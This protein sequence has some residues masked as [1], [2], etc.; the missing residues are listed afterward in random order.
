VAD[1][2]L[3]FQFHGSSAS[4]AEALVRPETMRSSTSVR[5]AIGSTPFSFA[6][7]ISVI[8]IAPCRAPPSLPANKAFLRLWKAF[9]SRNYVQSQIMRS[10]VWMCRIFKPTPAPNCA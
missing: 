4:R 1:E 6:V 2:R 7:W 5:Y 10:P 8:A 9:H 3:A